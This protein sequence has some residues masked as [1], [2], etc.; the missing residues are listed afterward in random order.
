[1]LNVPVTATAVAGLPMAQAGVAAA[2]HLAWWLLAACGLLIGAIGLITT[3]RWAQR[4]ATTT[5][6]AM[7]E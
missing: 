6:A 7:A 3:S 2:S 5:A 4:T 1:M